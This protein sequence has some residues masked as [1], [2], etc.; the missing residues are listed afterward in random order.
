MSTPITPNQTADYTRIEQAIRYLEQ[1]F[2]TQPDLKAVA[3]H[4][5][6]SEYHFQRLFTR[7]AGISPKRFLQFLTVEYAKQL[8]ADSQDLLHVTYEAGLSSPSRLHDLFITSEAVTPG[9]FKRKGA[10]LTIVYG[11][12]DTPFGECLLAMT[13]RGICGLTFVVDGE[14]ETALNGLRQN[15]PLAALQADASQTETYIQRIFSP[16]THPAPLKLYLQGSNFQLKVWQ[17]LLNIPLGTAVSYDTIA[18]WIGNPKASRA[19]GTAL[20]HNPVGYLIPCHRVIRKAGELGQYRWGSTRKKA[21]L[22]WE[23][24]QREAR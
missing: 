20:S 10:G 1:N 13:E 17:A 9:E 3:D 15:W 23:A 22:G 2:H 14:R 11:F 18:T 8:L 24:A 19:I 12:H 7:W 16:P 21:I 5:G 6:L 4:I